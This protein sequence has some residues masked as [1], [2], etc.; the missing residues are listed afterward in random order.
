MKCMYVLCA[1]EIIIDQ[2]TNKLSTINHIEEIISPEFPIALAKF[3]IAII[4]TKE[5]NDPDNLT[6]T[7]KVSNGPHD[8]V[9]APAHVSFVGASKARIIAQFEGF[10]LPVLAPVKIILSI[11]DN[12]IVER[13]IEVQASA[14]K[15]IEPPKFEG[16]KVAIARPQLA[17]GSQRRK[18]RRAPSTTKSN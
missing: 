4:L 17:V 13:T 10:P 1:E 12:T 7:L 2:Q 6:P 3:C 8:L 14:R 9:T 18:T 5:K 11:D 16:A 15:A